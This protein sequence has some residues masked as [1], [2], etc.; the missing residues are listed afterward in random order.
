MCSIIMLIT[1]EAYGKVPEIT[2]YCQKWHFLLNMFHLLVDL[3][4]LFLMKFVMQKHIG[5]VV[6]AIY[7][8]FIYL[9]I[10]SRPLQI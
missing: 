10:F 5:C 6:D 7:K 8:V 4:L 9:F 1:R 2:C 3:Y